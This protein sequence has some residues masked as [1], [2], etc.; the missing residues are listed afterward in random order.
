MNNTNE[1]GERGE[2]DGL[3]IGRKKRGNALHD[4]KTGEASF[5]RTE[6]SWGR[7]FS[8]LG[9]FAAYLISPLGILTNHQ[10]RGGAGMFQDPYCS[11]CYFQ[12]PPTR[13]VQVSK[14]P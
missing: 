13:S 4:F 12:S 10:K 14:T 7:N 11:F 2:E 9:G 8:P 3:R 1:E 6:S 5:G